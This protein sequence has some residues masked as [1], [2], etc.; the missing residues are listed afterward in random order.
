[1]TGANWFAFFYLLPMLI[2]VVLVMGIYLS[3]SQHQEKQGSLKRSIYQHTGGDHRMMLIL[4][5]LLM[6][7]FIPLINWVI[8]LL[9]TTG[10]LVWLAAK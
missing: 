10:Y 7:G 4:M 1:M 8:T 9:A 5:F 3:Y 6:L 2:T